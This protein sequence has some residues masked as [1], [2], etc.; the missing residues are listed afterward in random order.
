LD[1][2]LVAAEIVCIWVLLGYRPVPEPL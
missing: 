1:Y 2:V